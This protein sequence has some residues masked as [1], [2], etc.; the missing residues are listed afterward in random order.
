MEVVSTLMD[1][2]ER[3]CAEEAFQ[4]LRQLKLDLAHMNRLSLMGEL[5]ASLAHEIT[6]PIAAARNNARAAVNFLDM[7][8]PDLNEVGDALHSIVGDADRAGDIVDRIRDQIKKA[9]PRKSRFDLNEAIDEVIG[10]ARSAITTN[11]V[12]VRTRLAEA[13]VVVEGDRVQLQQVVLNL[14]L[15]AVEAMS[16]VEAGPLELSISTEQT[17]TGGVL[18]SVRNSGPGIDPD[19]LERVFQAFYTTKPSGGS[20]N[21]TVDL[22]INHR[23]SSGPAVGRHGRIRRSRVSVLL[24]WRRQATHNF[25]H[26]ARLTGEPCSSN[27]F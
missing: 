10:L 11:G 13:L 17:Q 7:Q 23:C 14:I 5:A 6:Q 22:P 16:T 27:G 20:R 25:R 8:P 9:P 2:T 15:N 26:P 4:R 12:T 21:G 1:V 24:A 19:Y 18:V 3:K